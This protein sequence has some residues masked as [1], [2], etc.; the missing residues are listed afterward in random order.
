MRAFK[1]KGGWLFF[2]F[3]IF[4]AGF[5]ISSTALAGGG[6]SEEQCENQYVKL[7]CYNMSDSSYCGSLP[8]TGC[9][10]NGVCA[11]CGGTCQYLSNC[12]RNFSTCCKDDCGVMSVL[13]EKSSVFG[14]DTRTWWGPDS[15]NHP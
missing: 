10:E 7:D 5:M 4:M 11:V 2:S 6:P 9:L 13:V 8:G 14:D 1:K 12:N 3:L 15:W